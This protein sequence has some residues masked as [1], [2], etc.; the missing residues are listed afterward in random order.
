MIIDCAGEYPNPVPTVKEPDAPRVNESVE[1]V[2]YKSP[3]KPDV[4]DVP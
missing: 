3:F 2:L 4:P 1:V